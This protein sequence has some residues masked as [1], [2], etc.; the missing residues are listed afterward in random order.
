MPRLFGKRKQN[1]QQQKAPVSQAVGP[2]NPPS[3]GGN[4]FT[5]LVRPTSSRIQSKPQSQSTTQTQQLSSARSLDNLK[6]GSSE[7]ASQG[8]YYNQPPLPGQYGGEQ[9]ENIQSGYHHE[10]QPAT[11]SAYSQPPLSARSVSSSSQGNSLWSDHSI[12]ENNPFPRRGFSAAYHSTG[13]F[14][15]GG[16]A[17]GSLSNELLTLDSETFGVKA[18]MSKGEVPS[19]R[20]GHSGAFIGRTLFVFGGELEDGRCDENLYAYNIANQ[21]WYKVPIASNIPVGRKGH[22]VVSYSSAIFVF[23]GTFNGHY[24][25]DLIAFDVRVATKSSPAWTY[26]SPIGPL[27]PGRAGHS[28]NIFDQNIYIFGGTDSKTCFNDLWSFSL[29]DRVWSQIKPLGATPPARYGHAS[30]IA[31]G[32]IYIM[33]GRTLKGEPLNDFF[34]YKISSQRWYTF[35]T[36][37]SQ[38]PSCIDPVFSV[39][40]SKLFLYSGNP[41][42]RDNVGT[43]HILDTAKIKIMRDNE[44]SSQKNNPLRTSASFSELR[45]TKKQSHNENATLTYQQNDALKTMEKSTSLPVS[46]AGPQDKVAYERHMINGIQ[47][48]EGSEENLPNSKKGLDSAAETSGTN[49]PRIPSG[50]TQNGYYNRQSQRR[51]IM[52]SQGFPVSANGQSQNQTQVSPP[53]SLNSSSRS[54]GTKADSG[55]DNLLTIALR[56]RSSIHQTPSS[57]TVDGDINNPSD[58]RDNQ[59]SSQG[60][61]SQESQLAPSLPYTNLNDGYFERDDEQIQKAWKILESKISSGDSPDMTVTSPSNTEK[62]S[63]NIS[64]ALIP[65]L[66]K[67]RAELTETKQQLKNV[68]SVAIEK[69]NEAEKSRLVAVQEA[70]YLKAKAKALSQKNPGVLN[71]ISTKRIAHIEGELVTAISEK[72]K[73]SQELSNANSCT[74]Q[75]KDDIESYKHEL[76]DTQQQLKE[77][78]EMYNHSSENRFSS[79]SDGNSAQLNAQLVEKDQK[80]AKLNEII[81]IIKS[82]EAEQNTTIESLISASKTTNQRAER[83]QNSLTETLEELKEARSKISALESTLKNQEDEIIAER[84]RGD[85]FERLFKDCDAEVKALRSVVAIQERSE[86]RD[87]QLASL[88]DSGKSNSQESTLNSGLNPLSISQDSDSR[89]GSSLSFSGSVTSN[90]TVNKDLH[91]AYLEAQKQRVE[92]RGK[93]L[94]TRQALR[95]QTEAHRQTQNRLSDRERQVRQMYSQFDAISHKITEAVSKSST[96]N[97]KIDNPPSA[98]NL[99]EGIDLS[100]VELDVQSLL[101]IIRGPLISPSSSGLPPL[102]DENLRPASRDS[103]STTSSNDL[104]R[105]HDVPKVT[106][107][108]YRHSAQNTVPT[109]MRDNMSTREPLRPLSDRLEQAS[110][111]S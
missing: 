107:W 102:V 13:L 72:E 111:S 105:Y 104:S 38:W 69:I 65:I 77:M 108:N 81:S 79:S 54:I 3:E 7:M 11:P 92:L 51:S 97:L 90:S 15:F 103:N 52:L 86:A 40:D 18:I 91:K 9:K 26:I 73:L 1:N 64:D 23:G 88:Q 106:S 63:I 47:T 34:V 93:L 8:R 87:R 89:P 100:H 22:T 43:I 60:K 36:E 85:H 109:G 50:S 99:F 53:S 35:P 95:E 74:K 82:T 25:Q 39:V 70:I 55:P 80:I 2:E 83:L 57:D 75:L 14:W 28:C 67:M 49:Q 68:S 110:T 33:G 46:T 10:E 56:N 29:V 98:G 41:G 27:P 24:L 76:Y 32:C 4:A 45:S 78:E 19:P 20:E 66:V 42:S 37:S 31:D 5:K 94:S 58:K 17:N 48:P 12:T 30:A 44:P 62:Q 21:T 101:S 16:K 96:T 84:K 59:D 61:N 71:K 6:Y